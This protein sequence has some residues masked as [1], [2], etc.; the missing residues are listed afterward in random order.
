MSDRPELI[1]ESSNERST[2][3]RRVRHTAY[4]ALLNT[5]PHATPAEVRAA[6]VFFSVIYSLIGLMLEKN[7]SHFDVDCGHFDADC[8]FLTRDARLFDTRLDVRWFP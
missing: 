7:C 5:P 2:F 1:G 6:Y 8:I 3:P 4:Y